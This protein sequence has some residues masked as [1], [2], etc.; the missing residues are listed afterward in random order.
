MKQLKQ[1]KLNVDINVVNKFLES[2]T[3]ANI[4][5]TNPFI[6]EYEI[7]EEKPIREYSLS[8]PVKISF[9]SGSFERK[10]NNW[11][12]NGRVW[13][14]F[15]V[16]VSKILIYEEYI[17]FKSKNDIAFYYLETGDLFD[18]NNKK[19]LQ[20][21]TSDAG[22]KYK[23]DQ[24]ESFDINDDEWYREITEK[25]IIENLQDYGIIDR[26]K[27]ESSNIS[28][29]DEINKKSQPEAY[30]PRRHPLTA[31]EHRLNMLEFQG[32]T[33]VET[34]HKQNMHY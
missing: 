8:K 31:E 34:K 15:D 7:I 22:E 18:K 10:V 14:N 30:M 24:P 11:G 4:I 19:V 5:N 6:I 3:N 32:F 1:F 17:C 26:N 12:L 21:G 23:L 20:Y 13:V 28:H 33:I 2:V 27:N 25:N 9:Q 16:K 29:S